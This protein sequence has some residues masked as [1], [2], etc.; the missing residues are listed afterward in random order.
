MFKELGYFKEYYKE[1]KLIGISNCSKDR[2]KVGYTGR[3]KEIL[4]SEVV[5]TNKKRLKA[6]TEYL[7]IIYPLC[8]KIEN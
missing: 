6:N 3:K 8:G 5:L 1:G 2:E 4:A 7:T